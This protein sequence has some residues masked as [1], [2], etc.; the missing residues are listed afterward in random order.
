MRFIGTIA[1]ATVLAAA[2]AG[3]TNDT[4]YPRTYAYRSG[5]TY[6]PT[7]YYAT[8]PAPRYYAYSDGTYSGGRYY[9]P[10]A[11]WNYG[12]SSDNYYASRWDYYRNYQGIHGGPE[13]T[14]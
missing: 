6:Y 14:D 4:Y 7:T 1:T 11:A 12:T 8:A 5:Y 9:P 2:V 3:C 10:P 13:R